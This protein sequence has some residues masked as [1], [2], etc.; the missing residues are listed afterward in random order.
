MSVSARERS[1][2]SVAPAIDDRRSRASHAFEGSS[3]HYWATPL[4]RKLCANQEVVLVGAGNSAGQAVVYLA[5]QIA[6]LWVLVRG[7]SLAASMSRYLVE[8]IEGLTNIEVVTGAQ[9]SGLEA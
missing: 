6:K 2:S 8:R 5:S 3:V 4:E 7:G 9:I 1:S